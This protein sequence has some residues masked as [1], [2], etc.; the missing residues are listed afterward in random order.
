MPFLLPQSV[1]L[2]RLIRRLEDRNVLVKSGK[3]FYL[4]GY[5]EREKLLRISISR[6]QPEQIV[7]GV[8]AIAEET[9]RAMG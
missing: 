5:L 4:S 7:Q 8:R 3:S 1:N 6:V 2:E 9:E